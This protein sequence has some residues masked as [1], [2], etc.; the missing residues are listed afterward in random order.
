LIQSH[1]AALIA[2][3]PRIE[4]VWRHDY[5]PGLHAIQDNGD[6]IVRAFAT[7]RE[8]HFLNDAGETVRTATNGGPGWQ[9]SSVPRLGLDF[10]VAI[11]VDETA[12][13]VLAVKSADD[14][15]LE[16]YIASGSR[17]RRKPLN[18]VQAK[19]ARKIW[20]TFRHVINKPLADCTLDD[21]SALVRHL[22]AEHLEAHKTVI[23]AAT[24][25]RTLV[26]LVALVDVAVAKQKL[27]LAVNPFSGVVTRRDDNES[28]KVEGFTD[29]DVK[30]IHANL[31]KLDKADQL[32]LRVIA[33]TGMDRGEAFSIA[34]ERIENGVR[35]CLI[36]TKT[37][38]R[39]RRIPFPKLLLPHLPKHITAPLF[40]GRK[41]SASKRITAFLKEIGI[42]EGRRTLAPL[43]S[44]RHRAATKLR[45]ARVDAELRYAIG[46]WTDGEKPNSGWNYG[47]WPIKVLRETIDKIGGL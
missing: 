33:S 7:D 27:K 35:Y 47:E 5:K 9:F 15:L 28:S 25:V 43:H 46:G 12:R 2:A 13:P 14:A 32:L 11:E 29:E 16:D 38:A 3:K 20:E 6:G 24:L 31:H 21:G 36:G 42:M 10:P 1:K 18:A 40:A 34:G 4:A 17:R 37:E 44:F 23:K 45:Q 30:L 39:P 41:D 8:V 22:E 19:A 26:P